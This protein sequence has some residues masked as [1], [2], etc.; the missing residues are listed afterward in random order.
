MGVDLQW[1][2]RNSKI[3]ILLIGNDCQ[4]STPSLQIPKASKQKGVINQ[5]IFLITLTVRFYALSLQSLILSIVVSSPP[6]QFIVKIK[7]YETSILC[8][9]LLLSKASF[10]DRSRYFR[11]VE[12]QSRSPTLSDVKWDIYSEY[13]HV[14]VKNPVASTETGQRSPNICI[15]ANI[16]V[17]LGAFIYCKRGAGSCLSV[18]YSDC[19]RIHLVSFFLLKMESPPVHEEPK[20]S[21][22]CMKPS[23]ITNYLG[24]SRSCEHYT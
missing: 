6:T 24:Y 19:W 15:K 10:I 8:Q 14:S 23:G 12:I 3:T 2:R 17:F 21:S 5:Y 7:S 1:N 4:N 22:V 20:F 16:L 9:K 18:S 11:F 13:I